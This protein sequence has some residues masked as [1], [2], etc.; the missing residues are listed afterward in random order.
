MRTRSE[1]VLFERKQAFTTDQITISSRRGGKRLADAAGKRKC[2]RL[3][4]RIDGLK[5][6][7]HS[8][9]MLIS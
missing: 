7:V 6:F 4:V 8:L 2:A 1:S 5:E 9:R 3:T